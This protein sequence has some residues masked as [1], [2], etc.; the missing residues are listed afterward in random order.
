M[1][2]PLLV[3][4]VDGESTRIVYNRLA[5][6]FG[7]FPAILEHPISGHALLR[8]RLRKLGLLAVASQ[9][10][11]LV[12]VRP[13]IGRLGKDRIARIKSENRL[14]ASPIPAQ[15]VSRVPSVNSPET[16]ELI[17]RFDPKIIVVNGTRIISRNVLGSTRATFINTHAGITP[18]YRGAHGGYWALYNDDLGRCGVT[19]HLV[20][21]GIDTGDI[22]GQALIKPT[23]KD[24]FVTYP[25]LQ[26]VA[27]LPILLNAVRSA[28]GGTLQSKAITGE[29]AVWYHPGL[30]QY[31]SGRL[32]GIR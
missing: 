29:S 6:E 2:V 11:F 26:I 5:Q 4:G 28:L 24:S 21:P 31:L 19:V 30:L 7:P 27:A 20:D 9:L 16:I 25:Y 10:A 17:T 18:K 8:I 32:R 12:C 22:V 23:R 3:L 14:D 1:N 13:I 15:N